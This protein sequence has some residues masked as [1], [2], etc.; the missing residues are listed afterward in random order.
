MRRLSLLLL[1]CLLL[2]ATPLLAQGYTST[3]NKA[4]KEYERGQAALLQGKSDQAMRHFEKAAQMDPAFCEPNLMLADWHLDAG[5][6][7]LAMQYY[8]AALQASPTFFPAAWLSLGDL[9][10]E[11]GRLEQAAATYASALRHATDD[12]MR[13]RAQHGADCAQFRLQAMAHP[14]PFSP[15]NVG[16]GV[17]SP[18]DEYL[19]ALTADGQTL[20]FTRRA[21][22]RA[23][24]TAGTPQEEDFYESRWQ[25]HRWGHAVRM[26]EPLNSTDNEG[27]QCISRDGR[28][29]VFTAC[30]RPDGGGRC[31]LY[32][33]TRHGDRWTQPRNMGPA[34]NTAAW[35]SQ[36]SLSYDGRTLYFV[37]DRRDGQGG[38]DIWASTLKDGLWTK[39]RNLGPAVNTAGDE[40]SPFIHFDNRTLY[41]A[42]TGHVGLGGSDLF[43]C[44]RQ[45]DGAWGAPENLGYPI[46]TAGDESN[47]IVSADGATAYFSSDKMGGAGRQDIYSFPL[48]PPLQPAAVAY[49]EPADTLASLK[50]GESVALDNIFFETARWE[51]LDVSKVALDHVAEALLAH[52]AMQVEIGGHTDAVGDDASNLRLSQQRAQAV[53]EYLVSRGVPAAR[54]AHKGY[55]ETQPVATNDTEEGRAQNRRTTFT[56]IATE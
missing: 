14:V 5:N 29:M 3:N 17:N 48:P 45:D 36:P 1:A 23:T 43:L 31:D 28:I 25:G 52:P 21:P 39:P 2:A 41:F 12:D 51:L 10:L 32:I 30:G 16:E 55:G 56:V 24:T 35:E 18:H 33:C 11:E 38:T 42:S 46:N 20:V 6:K 54:L 8:A 49:Q 37:S 44:R 15:E 34:I 7:P 53:R 26:P 50:V 47:L 4:I 40:S 22:R 9:Q 13:R 19:P 27:A